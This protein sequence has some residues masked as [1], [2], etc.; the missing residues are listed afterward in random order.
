MGALSSEIVHLLKVKLSSHNDQKWLLLLSC[1]SKFSGGGP[2]YP[3]SRL[4]NFD[5][6]FNSA[7]LN[8]SLS[9]FYYGVNNKSNFSL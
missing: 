3:P 5:L 4:E 7:L 9:F 8:T 1:Y 6:F 2:P